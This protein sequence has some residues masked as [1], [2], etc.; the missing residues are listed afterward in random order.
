MSNLLGFT[1]THPALLGGLALASLPIIIHL[2]NRR[3]FKMLEWAAMDF[4][5]KAAVRNRKRVRLE[6]LLLLLLRTL[7]VVLLILAVARPFTQ[8]ED[9][10]ASLFGSEGQTERIVLLDDS[11]SM[12]AGQGNR[13]AFDVAKQLTAKLI[14]RLNSEGSDDRI[15][16][17]LASD[18]HGGLEGSQ[19]VAAASANA[20]RL[21]E[22]IRKLKPSDGVL[23]PTA[24]IG[25]QI[26]AW[27][28][29]ARFHGHRH[30]S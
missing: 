12:K 28:W 10:L 14:E 18:P 9:A 30:S 25:R 3:R 15:T 1:F 29:L 11:H 22:R 7:V 6:N 8:A 20:L 4:L 16:L 13:A 5:L 23:D 17:V 26:K 21:A 24:A 2:L 19:S 27:S